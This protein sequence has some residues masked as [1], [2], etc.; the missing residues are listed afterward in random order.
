MRGWGEGHSSQDRVSRDQEGTD[1]PWVCGCSSLQGV[2]I[3]KGGFLFFSIKTAKGC[4]CVFE[5]DRF[6]GSWLCLP[7][8]PP[9][10]RLWVKSP[11]GCSGYQR[12]RPPASR[13]GIGAGAQRLP[14]LWSS[15]PGALRDLAGGHRPPSAT[16]QRRRDWQCILAIRAS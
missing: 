3:D 6:L 5:G 9:P 15:G 14:L 11:G 16:S 2:G 1:Q 10:T 7:S 13:Q 8:P 4:F 12:E